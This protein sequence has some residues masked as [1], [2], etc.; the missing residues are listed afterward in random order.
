MLLACE[1]RIEFL[2]YRLSG[3]LAE[4]EGASAH[5]AHIGGAPASLLDGLNFSQK[6]GRM[7]LYGD[8]LRLS[9]LIQS[10]LQTLG[11]C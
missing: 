4:A 7:P 9:P 10:F 8:L 2:D 1:D 5:R 11:C 3:K 6:L